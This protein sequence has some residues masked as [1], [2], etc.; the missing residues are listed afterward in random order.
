MTE[1]SYGDL[2]ADSHCEDCGHKWMFSDR[3]N[4]QDKGKMEI[5][6][7]LGLE[8]PDG[9][10][11][12]VAL[13]VDAFN[14]LR[15]ER[16]RYLEDRHTFSDMLDEARNERDKLE[17]WV[18]DLQSGMYINC[19]NCG[20]R[21]GP[22]VP[23]TMADVLKEHIEQCPEHPMSALKAE[24]DLMGRQLDKS[25]GI[26]KE[27]VLECD[28]LQ[29]REEARDKAIEGYRHEVERRAQAIGI[30]AHELTDVVNLLF[31]AVEDSVE[32]PNH[33][34]ECV[35]DACVR[36]GKKGGVLG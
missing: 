12:P 22:K 25:A 30:D 7:A 1:S 32:T 8:K 16:D 20:H 6:N 4:F 10:F 28:K 33:R 15:E 27:L 24:R 11:D 14:N 2:P 17:T 26:E 34:P 21:Y 9:D 23:A 19:V 5:I 18:N 35:C 36:A 13:V 3:V 29:R 31:A